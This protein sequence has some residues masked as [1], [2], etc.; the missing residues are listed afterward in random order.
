MR[1]PAPPVHILALS[2]LLT[3][4]LWITCMCVETPA[5]RYKCHPHSQTGLSW[6]LF[7]L[8]NIFF[9]DVVCTQEMG[10]REEASSGL[11]VGSGPFWQ[12]IQGSRYEK[13][14]LEGEMQAAW[15]HVPLAPGKPCSVRKNMVTKGQGFSSLRV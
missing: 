14:G 8:R 4:A 13:H 6:P 9:I 5:Y 15:D 1:E 2:S 10:L 3:L 12:G 11:K 7:G